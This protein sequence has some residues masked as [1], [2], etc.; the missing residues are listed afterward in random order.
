MIKNMY[1]TAA[2]FSPL[3]CHKCWV[4]ILSIN[5]L[6][7]D[8]KISGFFSRLGREFRRIVA[9]EKYMQKSYN[10]N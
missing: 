4:R 2:I 5:Y 1:P 10:F 3:D 7:K 8:L 6:Y 9:E